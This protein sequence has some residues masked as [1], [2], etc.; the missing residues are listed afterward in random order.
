MDD[1]RAL[2]VSRDD[3][4][5]DERVLEPENERYAA[6]LVFVHG[7]WSGPDVWEPVARG[8]A[9][10]G[11]RCVLLD[12]SA[13]LADPPRDFGAWVDRAAA[14]VAARPTPPILLGHDA[15]ALVALAIAARGAVRAAVA[16]APLLEGAR[17]LV[18]T[19][20]RWRARWSRAPLPA[21]ALA[22]SYRQTSTAAGA[23]RLGSVLS[24][25]LASRITSLRGAA[26]LPGAAPVPVLLAAQRD[27][28]AVSRAS[29]EITARGVAADFRALPGGHWALLEEG[30][31]PWIS[32]LH[33]WIIRRVGG[34]LLL[35]R[36]DED[37]RDE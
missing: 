13:V 19:G 9:H 22:T 23:A 34:S 11:W 4:M 31:D 26:L 28:A 30:I 8:F 10:R 29:I 33:R 21:A 27:D 16:I 7:L 35:L 17:R 14:S 37:L 12:H 36:G 25:E 3:F 1:S 6:E 20:A 18:T 2:G 32:E 5:S 24:P 15:G